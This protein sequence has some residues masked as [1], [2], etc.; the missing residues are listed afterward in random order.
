[1]KIGSRLLVLFTIA[2]LVSSS[3]IAVL[4]YKS[5]PYAD[6]QHDVF[7]Q[8][9]LAID[10]GSDSDFI[11]YGWTGSGTDIDPFVLQN[12]ALGFSGEFGYIQIHDTDSYFEIR[13]C[14]FLFFD[15][16]FMDLSN[17][18]I[19]D[20]TFTNSSIMIDNCTDCVI[21]DNEL[22]YTPYSTELIWLQKTS[23][24]EIIQN[25]LSNGFTGIVLSESNYTTISENSLTDLEHGGISGDF[26]N[27]T[28]TNN[29]FEG[30]GFRMEYWF[31]R[32][33]EYPPTMENNT[34]NGKEL[35]F[36]ISLV[37]EQI[38]TEQY[39]QVILGN[40][41][42]TVVV[43]GSFID[44]S[45]GVQIIFCNNCTVSGATISDCSWEGITVDW[46][47]QTQIIDS[48]ISNCQNEG[49][50]LS[51]SPFYKIQNCTIEDNLN[52]IL[53]HI[54]SNNGTISNCTIRGNKPVSS[55]YFV[56][57]A[58]IHLS[59][60]STVVGNTI[61]D[62]NVGIFIYGAN[63]LV[64]D[65]VITHNGYGIYIGEAYTGYGERPSNNRIY[66]NDIGWNYLANAHD[67]TLR[68][69]E[70]DDGISVGNR[71]SDYYG[72]GY[73][74]IYRDTVD[75]FPRLLPEGAIPLFIIHLSVGISSTI[76]IVLVLIVLLKKRTKL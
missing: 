64:V 3:T 55:E 29:V 56:L 60:N 8:S 12:Q 68:Y 14:Q 16:Y 42:D 58:G 27:T 28:L 74:V 65:N 66:N 30:T 4:G 47:A 35:G 10:I 57:E 36:F 52:G 61:T 44:C 25:R 46:S 23:G 39:G 73:Y 13:N 21:F 9:Y 11:D 43:G 53:P 72:I 26:S 22:S 37:G 19:E 2:C 33:E 20:C 59:S 32:M 75:H 48:Q 7:T 51:S 45:T 69:N 40:C 63:C 15:V 31:P 38:D 34:I 54:Y 62:N 67:R 5:S 70:W 17:G 76:I 6:A 18:R 50:F 49:I 41:N 71:W 24:C 1:M